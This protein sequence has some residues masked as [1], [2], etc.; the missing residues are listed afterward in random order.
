MRA[1]TVV[2][3]LSL[4]AALFACQRND[5]AKD[6]PTSGSAGMSK[7]HAGSGSATVPPPHRVEQI[8]PPLDLK[9][10]PPDATRRRPD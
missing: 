9:T 8:A 1:V 10:P 5:S 4:A 6:K 7:N 2:V 3:S